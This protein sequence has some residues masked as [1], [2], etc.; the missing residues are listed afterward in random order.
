MM[1]RILALDLGAS[2]GRV[3]VGILKNDQLK[4]DEIYRVTNEGVRVMGLL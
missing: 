4:L 3:L 2:S 1:V